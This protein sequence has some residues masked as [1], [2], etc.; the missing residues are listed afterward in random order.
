MLRACC[1]HAAGM[2]RACCGH[3]AGMHSLLILSPLRD[4]IKKNVNIEN[5]APLKIEKSLDEKSSDNPV[6]FED[7][8]DD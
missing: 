8:K 1:G 3:A 7:V 6:D 4:V 2:L 5:L